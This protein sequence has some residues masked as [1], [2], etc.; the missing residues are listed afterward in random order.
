MICLTLRENGKGSPM[1]GEEKI[2]VRYSREEDA[3]AVFQA[4]CYVKERLA[5]PSVYVA[6]DLPYVK[7]HIEKDGFT[8]IAE[9]SGVLAGFLIVHLPGL[10]EE[11]L[12]REIGMEE[13]D[14]M[15][16]AHIESEA[17][18]PE[19]RGRGIQRLL[20]REA[21]KALLCRGYFFTM[22]TVSP[23]NPYSLRNALALGYQIMLTKE[24][25]GGLMRHI[26][27]KKLPA[28]GKP[29][30]DEEIGDKESS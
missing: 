30:M 1:S 24:K 18:L 3:E 11:N 13:E 21:E 10:G 27:L 8:L 12:G 17:V 2:H 26:L 6:D 5:N 4:M 14:L 23:E 19:Y 15:R 25:Y 9:R 20:L 29:K 28:Q 7:R 22:M 16:C